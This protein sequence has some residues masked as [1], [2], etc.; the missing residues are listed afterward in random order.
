MSFSEHSSALKDIEEYL[1]VSF[2]ASFL[3]IVAV[4]GLLIIGVASFLLESLDV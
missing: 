2:S 4:L 1:G 3:R